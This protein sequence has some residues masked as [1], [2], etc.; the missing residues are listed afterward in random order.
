MKTEAIAVPEEAITLTPPRGCV[1]YFLMDG[2]EC[3]YVGSS[4]RLLSRLGAHL[5]RKLNQSEFH[6]DHIRYVHVSR[7]KMAKTERY[8]IKTLRPRFNGSVAGNGVGGGRPRIKFERRQ[9]SAHLSVGL[10]NRLTALV[11]ERRCSKNILLTIMIE[12]EVE[13]MEN[14]GDLHP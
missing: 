1:V 12:N 2:E 8:W 11:E 9:I 5:W 10:Y 4:M 3:I 13:R 6:F 14:G 7:K